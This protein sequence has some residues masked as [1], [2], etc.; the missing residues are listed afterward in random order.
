GFLVEL[1]PYFA[2]A[3]VYGVALGFGLFAWHLSLG[4]NQPRVISLMS[5]AY[6]LLALPLLLVAV[7]GFGAIGA[8]MVQLLMVVNT[9][10]HTAW[11]W[12]IVAGPAAPSRWRAVFIALRSFAGAAL[13]GLVWIVFSTYLVL[14][15]HLTGLGYT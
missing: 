9:V 7:R 11:I 15:R 6:G 5:V 4:A 10:V 3:V 12:R 2:F 13:V 14:G 1:W 8:S